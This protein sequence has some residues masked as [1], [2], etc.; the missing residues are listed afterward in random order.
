MVSREDGCQSLYVQCVIM[1]RVTYVQSVCAWR[2]YMYMPHESVAVFR[3]PFAHA[4]KVPS[5][6]FLSGTIF[7]L[8]HAK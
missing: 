5:K 3:N 8:P 4:Q 1:S 6:T 7:A 2:V